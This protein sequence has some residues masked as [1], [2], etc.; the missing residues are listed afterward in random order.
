M[1]AEF[2]K[3]IYAKC[4]ED[5]LTYSKSSENISGQCQNL[6]TVS[7]NNS[8]IVIAI[9]PSLEVKKLRLGEV[10]LVNLG[11]EHS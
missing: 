5:Y 7:Q 10:S 2:F 9:M 4:L 8:D 6:A 3:L 1:L 11:K